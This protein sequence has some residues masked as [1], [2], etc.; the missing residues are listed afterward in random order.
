MKKLIVEEWFFRTTD[1][2]LF[3]NLTTKKQ[4]E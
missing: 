4:D 3:S 2:N 1:R